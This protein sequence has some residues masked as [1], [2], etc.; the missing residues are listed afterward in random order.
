MML[1]CVS[2]YRTVYPAKILRHLTSQAK[3]R[4][5]RWRSTGTNEPKAWAGTGIL[6]DIVPD[7]DTVGEGM[8]SH[9]V[10]VDLR[11]L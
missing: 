9:I 2:F 3:Q 11:V 7:V 1:F 4:S 10:V 6:E 5:G 8:A